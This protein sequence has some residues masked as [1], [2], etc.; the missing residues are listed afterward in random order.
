MSDGIVRGATFSPC[1][2]YR[3]TLTRVWDEDKPRVLF[4]LLNPSVADAEKDDPTNR[5]GMG[6]ARS[7]SLGACVFVNLFAFRTPDPK[8]MRAEAEPVGPDNDLHIVEQAQLADKVVIAWAVGGQHLGRD[9][10]V[11]R[12]LRNNGFNDL[13]RLG[14]PTRGGHPRYPLYLRA[15]T[16]LVK[17]R[18]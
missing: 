18:W 9:L 13:W 11:M 16:E 3:Y 12:M 1:M 17:H 2:R 10:A 5:R 15:D 4:I 7:W 6:F 14:K 8:V